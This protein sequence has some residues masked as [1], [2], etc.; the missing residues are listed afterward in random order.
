MSAGILSAEASHTESTVYAKVRGKLLPFLFVLYVVAYLDRINVGFAALQMNRELGLGP[1]VFGFGAGIFFIGYFALELPSNLVLQRVGARIWISRIMI[2]WGLAAMAMLFT[3]GPR[4]FYALRLLLGAAEAGF[5]PGII[6][7]LMRWFPARERARA[8]AMFMTATQVAGVI[9][10]PLSGALL[11]MDR[12]WGLSGW[13]WLFLAEGLPAVLLGVMVA[14]YLPD[15]P[16]DAR[17]LSPLER[18]VVVTALVREREGGDTRHTLAAAIRSGK[19]WLLALLYFTIVF[20]HYGIAVWLPQILRAL[21]G[22]SDLRIGLLSSIPF[23]TAAITMVVVGKHSD[24]RAERRLHLAISALIGGLALAASAAANGPFLSLITIS[25]A[26]AGISSTAGPF[27]TLPAGFLEGTAAAGG[28]ALINSTGNLAG[29]VGPSL[30]GFLKQATGSFASGLLAMA[31]V[32]VLAGLLALWI[33][34]VAS[35]PTR[36]SAIRSAVDEAS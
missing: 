28:I 9:G 17:W 19:V 26:A 29:F 35:S 25:I 27:W 14:I 12:I 30:V 8:V 32:V 33:P 3:R 24:A 11:S 21:G 7:Y 2:T 5:F 23:M 15:G 6:F 34:A 20:G 36:E 22:M 1:A 16:E 31:A 13:Q 10:G 4:S 18:S